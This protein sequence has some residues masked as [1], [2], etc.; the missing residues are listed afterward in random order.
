MAIQL[1]SLQPAAAGQGVG[2]AAGQGAGAGRQAGAG[3]RGFARPPQHTGPVTALQLVDR[4]RARAGLPPQP[5]PESAP[6]PNA[7]LAPPLTDQI[8]AGDPLTAVTGIATTAM[9]TFDCLKA[10]A[11]AKKNLIVTLDPV[12]WSE[13][14]SLDRMEGAAVF[15]AK[16]D[17]IRANN[18]VCFRLHDHWPAK[19]PNGI[20]T[21][22]AKDLGW[23]SY[24]EDA[25]NPTSFKVPQ[26]TLLGLARE[27]STKLNDRTMRVVGDPQLPVTNIA[28]NWGNTTQKQA[29]HLLNTSADVLL[30][31]YTWEW[32]GVEYAQDMVAAG[33]KKALILLGESRSLGG[34]MKYCAEWMKTFISEVPIEYIPVIEPYWNLRNPVLEI[35]TKI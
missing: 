5:V 2:Q 13:N 11:A 22:M 10:A 14:D 7:P 12:F 25:A 24:V 15:K 18:L 16:R 31:G 23:D 6:P 34:G 8:L 17:F 33:D 21:G 29:I 35:N 3:P 9:A 4:I 30:V 32:A 20:A 26:T 1:A 19:G 27:L 28:A